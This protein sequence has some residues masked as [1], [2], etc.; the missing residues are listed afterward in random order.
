ME[1]LLLPLFY[2][3][4]LVF[5]LVLLLLL[6]AVAMVFVVPFFLDPLPGMVRFPPTCNIV[7][8][9]SHQAVPDSISQ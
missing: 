3:L 1:E 8:V 7:D 5:L 6:L 4:V 9:L 2:F